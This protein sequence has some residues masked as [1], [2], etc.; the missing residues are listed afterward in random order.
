MEEDISIIN[1]KTRNEKVRNFFIKYQDRLLYASDLS[2]EGKDDALSKKAYM[3]KTWLED[4]RFFV[5]DDL[6]TNPR[7]NDE[8]NGLKL[9]KS[10]VD[11]I[12]YKN[13]QK[14]LKMFPDEVW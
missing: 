2:D 7:V 6:M 1:S 11:K 12:Y 13:A 14:W 8:F 3:H 9:P 4:W 5:T 10:V